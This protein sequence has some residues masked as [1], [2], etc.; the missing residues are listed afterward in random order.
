LKYEYFVIFARIMLYLLIRQGIRRRTHI[1]TGLYLLSIASVSSCTKKETVEVDNETQSVVDY[2]IVSGEFLGIVSAV[3][4]LALVTPGIGTATSALSCDTLHKISGDT[5]WGSATHVNPLYALQVTSNLCNSALPDGRSRTGT[6]LVTFTSKTDIPGAKMIIKLSGFQS[7]YHDG[8][9]SPYVCGCDSII[10]TTIAGGLSPAYNVKLVNG[11]CKNA[12]WSIAN[13]FEYT[14]SSFPNGLPIGSEP[15]AKFTG[16]A[17]G[18]NRQGRTYTVV[19][20][21]DEPLVRHR[22]CAYID[23][24]KANL[25]PESFKEREVN[26]GSGICDDQATFSVN[27]N[28]VAFKLK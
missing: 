6:V 1:L 28:T 10:V 4:Q 3:E 13:S 9:S 17:T 26:Y 23:A 8:T 16:M 27:S 19:I 14:M 22:A 11:T 18:L 20:N 25:T 7:D 5:L 21:N 2:S 24:G 12:S 15:F